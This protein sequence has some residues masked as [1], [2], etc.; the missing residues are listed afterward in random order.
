MALDPKFR[1]LLALPGMQL[2][3]PPVEVTPAMMR[4]GVKA[5]ASP[6]PPPPVHEVKNISIKGPTGAIA[7]RLYYPTS[8]RPLPVTVFAHGGGWVLCDL[9]SHDNLCRTLALASGSVIAAVDYRLAPEAKFPGPLEDCYAALTQLV[10][11]ASALG[12]DASRVA[13]CGDSAGANLAA[14]LVLL[15]R[16]RKG[17]AICFQALMWPVT[18]ASCT[19][20]SYTSLGEGYML[21]RDI[22]LWFWECYLASPQ[23]ASNPLAAPLRE[24]NLAGLPPASIS[25][26]EYD[27]LRDEGE[28]YADALRE[29]GVNVTSRR[30]LGMI[31]GFVSFPQVTEV[32]AR[33]LADL[34]SDLAAAL[35]APS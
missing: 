13:V 14:A 25:T 34:G 10:A 18:D 33:A 19:S 1:A 9:E 7:V 28:A 23:D 35:Y 22:M 2:G 4:E 17:P 11:Q 8:V 20:A 5:M 29:A 27:V 3:R 31:H 12:L 30:Y 6:L 26:C 15:A 21:S 32:A 16:E 24:K